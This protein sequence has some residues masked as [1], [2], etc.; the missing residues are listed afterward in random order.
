MKNHYQVIKGPVITERTTQLKEKENKVV[1]EVNVK[2]NK[3]EIKSAVEALFKVKVAAVNVQNYLGK[4]KRVGV[5]IG[6][7]ADWKKAI[8][9]LGIGE[10]LDFLEG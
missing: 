4:P 5:H 7:R 3:I 8:V 6:K 1:F 9:T 2:A 10:K